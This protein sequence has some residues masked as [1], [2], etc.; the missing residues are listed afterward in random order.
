MKTRKPGRKFWGKKIPGGHYGE[1]FSNPGFLNLFFYS[2][3]L[4]FKITITITAITFTS[5]ITL[6]KLTNF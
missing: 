5:K 6:K 3:I 2:R 4:V 1:I